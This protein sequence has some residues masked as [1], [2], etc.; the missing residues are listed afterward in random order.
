MRNIIIVSIVIVSAFIVILF[1]YKSKSDRL[2][3]AIMEIEK[4]K[5][6]LEA[7]Q[8]QM[9]RMR[10]DAAKRDN[11]AVIVYERVNKGAIEYAEKIEAVESDP[12][13]CDWLDDTL[14]DSVRKYFKC[15]GNTDGAHTS[16]V[17]PVDS[18]LKTSARVH[19]N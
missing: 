9:D 2:D 14:P 5:T 17:D 7:M 8:D 19:D 15:E 10:I 18:M 6:E 3:A 4:T 13:S 1:A 16:P 12:D 11:S